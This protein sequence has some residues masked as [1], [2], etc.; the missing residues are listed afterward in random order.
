V[1]CTTGAPDQR[2]PH[3]GRLVARAI[4]LLI[5]L[6]AASCTSSP[7]SVP[8]S[9]SE[10]PS[11]SCLSS[12]S[13]AR[14]PGTAPKQVGVGLYACSQGDNGRSYAVFGH[15]AYLIWPAARDQE[16]SLRPARCFVSGGEARKA[17]FSVARQSASR[18]RVGRV[19]FAEAYPLET[20][21][22]EGAASRLPFPVPCPKRVPS[23]WLGL[24]L[25]GGCG[26]S[27][28]M[29]VLEGYFHEPPGQ[30]VEGSS[31]GHLLLW[32]TQPSNI[33][34]GIIGCSVAATVM[35]PRVLGSSATFA[36]CPRGDAP[37][38]GHVL[39]TWTR[40]R[41]DYA[42]SVHGNSRLNRRVALVVAHELRMVSQ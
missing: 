22:C 18:R 42:V 10:R 15:T 9:L 41:V 25:T 37:D 38:S 40:G 31:V 4:A 8:P 27:C 20:S 11:A 34:R 23:G 33:S 12:T 17:G 29:F 7:S 35:A 13:C 30:G 28:G 24:P 19:E 21:L 2:H 14:V 5:G 16:L 32:A 36:T 26:P 6:S 1:L 3:L 39:L